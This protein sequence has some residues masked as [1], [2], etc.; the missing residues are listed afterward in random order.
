MSPPIL[1]TLAEDG[2][3]LS[4]RF[5]SVWTSDGQRHFEALELERPFGLPYGDNVPVRREVDVLLEASAYPARPGDTRSSV[6]VRAGEVDR[7]LVIWGPR[8]ASWQGGVYRFSAPLPFEKVP[9]DHA[10][11]YGGGFKTDRA[12]PRNPC[13]VG[14]VT[15]DRLDGSTITL[16]QVE[17]PP[18]LLTPERLVADWAAWWRQPTPALVEPL[19][20]TN[21]PRLSHLP[22][23]EIYPPAPQHFAGERW[24]LLQEAPPHSRMKVLPEGT[25]V[26]VDG[27][28]PAGAVWRRRL[29]RPPRVR[30]WVEAIERHVEVLPQALRLRPEADEISIG[31][32]VEH[33]LHRA[34]IPG[35]H[36]RIPI[37]VEVEGTTVAYQAPVPVLSQLRAAQAREV[38]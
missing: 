37:T 19:V 33:K 21:L 22:F 31:Y 12:Y 27:C 6:R 4:V 9:L 2:R 30:L 32:A 10:H 34:F 24:E 14:F 5:R 36:A 11:A 7:A 29:P 15:S 28:L 13:G 25:E 35:I 20:P 8:Q 3:T 1:L 23:P 17:E 16:P 26:V 18:H 38:R